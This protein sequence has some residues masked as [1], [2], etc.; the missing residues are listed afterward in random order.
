MLPNYFCKKENN[1]WHIGFKYFICTISLMYMC[2][3]AFFKTDLGNIKP[4][5]TVPFLE[6][7]CSTSN[8]NP[9]T[10]LMLKSDLHLV[11]EVRNNAISPFST[12][13]EKCPLTQKLSLCSVRLFSTACIPIQTYG[14]HIYTH[15]VIY[16]HKRA[17][18]SQLQGKAWEN[19]TNKT[20]S[21]NWQEAPPLACMPNLWYFW[22]L[23]RTEST[24]SP[25]LGWRSTWKGSF[26]DLDT[27]I[28]MIFWGMKNSSRGLRFNCILQAVHA[29]I[30]LL[31]IYCNFFH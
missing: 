18:I 17:V 22:V 23:A 27:F 2:S 28:E 13:K 8:K 7:L 29:C 10:S 15:R 14:N 21:S 5:P 6:L 31:Q 24:I 9:G 20:I 25:C 3:S 30:K 16:I 4:Q 19:P 26:P 11:T 12:T 1:V